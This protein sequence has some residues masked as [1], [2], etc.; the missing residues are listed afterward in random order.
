MDREH[1]AQAQEAELVARLRQGD[2]DALEQLYRRYVDRLYSLVFY[3]VG[4]NKSVAEDIVQEIFLATLK[5]AHKFRGES[6]FYTWLCGIAYHKVNDF[7]RQQSRQNGPGQT[8]SPTAHLVLE[9][10][11]ET[12]PTA[13]SQIESHETK[14]VVEQALSRLPLS[15]RQ[16][17]I[18]KYVEQ[19]SVSEISL[20]M[21]RSP[22]SVEGILARAR[23]TLRTALDKLSEG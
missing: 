3:Q 5:S 18:F 22:K 21:G 12:E 4:R 19:M 6:K 1:R 2:R 11:A 7:Y 16:A 20:V 8:S 17:L 9:Q 10:I 13:Q 14:Q 23:K 15:Y